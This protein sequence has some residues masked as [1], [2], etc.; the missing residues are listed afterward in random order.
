[1]RDT[2]HTAYVHIAPWDEGQAP[3]GALSG[4]SGFILC[5]LPAGGAAFP[6]GTGADGASIWQLVR[7]LEGDQ[8]GHV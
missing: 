8:N 5:D 3:A 4:E 6:A 2:N 7:R 1:M